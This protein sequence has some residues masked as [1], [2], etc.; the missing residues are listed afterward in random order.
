MIE[1]KNRFLGKVIFK[2][3]KTITLKKF[4]EEKVNQRAYLEGA[5]LRGEDLRGADLEGADLGGACLRRADLEGADLEG[6]YL[7]GADLGGASLEVKV[8]PIM[9]K[10]FIS[11]ILYRKAKTETQIDF[12]SRIRMQYECKYNW[13]YFLRIARKKKVLL[14]VKKILFQW[15]EFEKKFKE[16]AA[17]E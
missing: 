1:I 4:L 17:D 3:K 11:E 15:K 8:P 13:E 7:G 5:D 14:W 16:E 10:Q 6:A 9:S 2:T 12:A